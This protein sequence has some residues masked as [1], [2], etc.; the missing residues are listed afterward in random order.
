MSHLSSAAMIDM[1]DPEN[2]SPLFVC[3]GHH[4][5]PQPACV[6]P[7]SPEA[8]HGGPV[9]ALVASAAEDAMPGDELVTTRLTLDL[10]RPVP[11]QPLEVDARVVKQGRR[12]YLVDVAIRH[13][14]RDVALARIQ[15]TTTSNVQLPDLQGTH[16][17]HEPPPEQPEQF[18]PFDPSLSPRQP[19]P[20]LRW[21]TELRTATPAGIYNARA[22]TAWLRVYADLTPDRPL[23]NAAAVAAACDYTN[24]LGAP[25]MPSQISNILFPNADLTIYLV[26]NPHSKWVRMA[27]QS[28]WCDHGIAH[29]RC[30]LW[31]HDGVLGTSAV[32]LPLIA[33]A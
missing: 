7:W 9:A 18:V 31:D 33:P 12:V 4:W 27:P 1:G 2:P 25:A 11:M 17:Q 23:S 14:G 13:N 5:L 30:L 21:A 19:A 8:L 26:R 15:R 3:D 29:S 22:K 6:G 24:A 10:V 28:A 16:A 20:F 32:T